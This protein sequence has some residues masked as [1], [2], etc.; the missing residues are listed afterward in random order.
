MLFSEALKKAEESTG[1]KLEGYFLGSMFASLAPQQEISEWTLHYY[2]PGIK[3][4]ID[5]TVSGT[6]SVEESIPSRET[7][8]LDVS[9]VKISAHDAVATAMKHCAGDI[10]RILLVL[11][12]PGAPVWNVNVISSSLNATTF[13]VDAAGGEILVSKSTSLLQRFNPSDDK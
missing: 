11:H 10:S 2:N 9:L 13:T 5:V 3:R 4:G 1:K 8:P 7:A 12:N 6:V